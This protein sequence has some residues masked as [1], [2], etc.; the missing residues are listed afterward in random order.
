MRCEDD[1]INEP[2]APHLPTHSGTGFVFQTQT[3]PWSHTRWIAVSITEIIFVCLFVFF[4]LPLCFK[5]GLPELSN[6]LIACEI[7][8]K[9]LSEINTVLEVFL[10][11]H[12]LGGGTASSDRVLD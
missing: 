9:V 4:R 2:E 11:F 7:C 5:Y 3:S 8:Q 12:T 1:K 10:S 6:D